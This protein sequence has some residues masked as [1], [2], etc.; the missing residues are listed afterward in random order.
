MAEKHLIQGGKLSDQLR[1]ASFIPPL[2]PRMLSVA[3]DS[4][5]IS[6]MLQHIADFYEDEMNKTLLKLTTLI[7]P[8]ILLFLGV[9]IGG[10]VLAVLLPL[11]DVGSFI[12]D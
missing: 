8:V 6:V 5:D 1:K 2:V 7:Q 3:E 4:G 12:S 11:M 9:I 10:I